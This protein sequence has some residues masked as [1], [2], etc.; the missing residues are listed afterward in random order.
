MFCSSLIRVLEI[1]PHRNSSDRFAKKRS[2]GPYFLLQPM[3]VLKYV[4][5]VLAGVILMVGCSN[6]WRGPRFLK[7]RNL[8]VAPSGCSMDSYFD[9]I[10]EDTEHHACTHTH[11]CNPPVLDHSHTHTCV[12]VHTK[13]LAASPDGAESP[14]ENN[15][16]KKRQVVIELQSGNT[17]KRRRLAQH[18]WKKK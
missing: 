10:L 9:N 13:I 2:V 4:I 7:P 17:V 8:S 1:C 6:G 15:G 18:H 16:S 5:L 14:S 11:I 3:A 12:H